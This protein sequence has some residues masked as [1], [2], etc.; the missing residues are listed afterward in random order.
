[1]RTC[2]GNHLYKCEPSLKEI[3]QSGVLSLIPSSTLLFP[4]VA[5]ANRSGCCDNVKAKKVAGPRLYRELRLALV[6]SRQDVDS[7]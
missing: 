2:R 4:L 1:M 6:Y 5:F 7:F 3:V